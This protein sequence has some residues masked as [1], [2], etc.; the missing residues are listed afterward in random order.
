MIS[1]LRFRQIT[2]QVQVDIVTL[3][4]MMDS[5]I[6]A[7]LNRGEIRDA[8]DIE[9]LIKRN[10]SFPDDRAKVE[11]VIKVIKKFSMSRFFPYESVKSLTRSF[12]LYRQ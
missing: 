1:F 11:K 2:S 9:F 12:L 8:F 7:L 5:K 3:E 10:V 6:Q 4:N